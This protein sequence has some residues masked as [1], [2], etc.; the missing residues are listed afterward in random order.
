MASELTLTP[1]EVVLTRH[2]ILVQLKIDGTN[3]TDI[4][5]IKDEGRSVKISHERPLELGLQALVECSWTE[6][7]PLRELGYTLFGDFTKEELLVLIYGMYRGTNENQN[8]NN[9]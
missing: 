5:L 8:E 3:E 2:P 1:R 6:G 9:R 4:F 7:E